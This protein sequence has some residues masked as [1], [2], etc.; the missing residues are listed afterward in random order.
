M[1]KRVPAQEFESI[2]QNGKIAISLKEDDE[3]VAVRPTLGESQIIIAAANGKA[4]R[5]DER[6]V[7]EM[8][9]NATGVKGMAVDDT[10]VI[11]MCT[12]QEGEMI[13]K[14]KVNA[15]PT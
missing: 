6:G 7:R 3:L 13:L 2:R 5:F 11:G 12:D 1:C 15:E 10:E 4:V 8:G 14:R 9:R